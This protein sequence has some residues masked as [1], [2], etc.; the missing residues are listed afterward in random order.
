MSSEW[1]LVVQQIVPLIDGTSSVKKIAAK[2]NV[3]LDL[4]IQ[5]FE[6][7]HYYGSIVISDIFQFSNTYS[8]T[9]AITELALDNN[10]MIECLAY[11]CYDD[12]LPLHVNQ[13][14]L[15]KLYSLLRPS[16]RVQDWTRQNREML[17]GIDCLRFISFGVTKGYLYRVHRYPYMMHR[18]ANSDSLSIVQLLDG[19][20]HMDELCTKFRKSSSD[21]ESAINKLGSVVYL[22]K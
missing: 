5:C 18:N 4:A 21:M 14:L 15:L 9:P 1:D 19:T 7:L 16:V 22:S 3:S 10:V 6:H 8:C 12:P 17:R 11:V 20:H 2:A 13:A